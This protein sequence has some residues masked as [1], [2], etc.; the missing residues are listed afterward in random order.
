[1]NG[2]WWRAGIAVVLVVAVLLVFA[3]PKPAT[4][5]VRL[6]YLPAAQSLPLFVAMEQGLFEKEGLGV[7]LQRMENPNQIIDALVVGKAD[8]GFAIATGISAVADT[9]KP[10][11]IR[12]NS[13]FCGTGET[14]RHNDALIVGVNSSISSFAD[15]RGKRLGIMPGIQWNTI[16]RKILKE[17][18]IAESEVTLVEL[19]ISNHLASLSSGGVDALLTIEPTVELGLSKGIAKIA[20]DTPTVKWVASPICLGASGLSAEFARK[21]PAEAEK[22]L[23]AVDAAIR[24]VQTNSSVRQYLV[25]YLSLSEEVAQAVPLP[26]LYS[27]SEFSTDVVG[28][29]Q[30]FADIF[31]E[32]NVTSVRPDARRL[33]L[34]TQ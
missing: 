25:R 9:K 6:V 19:P 22:Y 27:R 5:P 13:V 8:A 3:F 21:R 1:M 34:W 23:R 33:M 4:E 15:L 20:V 28:A 12:F 11:A 7:E 14:E 16:S 32:F 24:Q 29:Y 31:F 2:K 10:G 18:G 26:V 30:E 17:N